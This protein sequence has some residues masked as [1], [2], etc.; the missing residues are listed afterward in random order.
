MFS[1]INLQ[2]FKLFSA[3]LIKWQ[4]KENFRTENLSTDPNFGRKNF[5]T[6]KKIRKFFRPK[7]FVLNAL[8]HPALD[9]IQ[10]RFNHDRGDEVGFNQGGLL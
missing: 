8:N 10:Y 6:K 5:R 7:V 2:Y 4:K 1:F 3:I 9:L